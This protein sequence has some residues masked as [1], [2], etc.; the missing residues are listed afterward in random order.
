M[1]IATIHYY[2]TQKVLDLIT[3]EQQ[4][5]VIVSG[6][7]EKVFVGALHRYATVIFKVVKKAACQPCS[8]EMVEELAELFLG[9]LQR[10]NVEKGMAGMADMDEFKLDVN[11]V[12]YCD[13]SLC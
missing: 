9:I 1:K 5:T 2:F 6:Y 7:N 12:V 4:S 3:Q 8:L 11:R 10:D 13:H